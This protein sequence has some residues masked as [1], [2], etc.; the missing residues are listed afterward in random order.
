MCFGRA[1]V[2]QIISGLSAEV[3]NNMVVLDIFAPPSWDIFGLIGIREILPHGI[4]LDLGLLE[5]FELY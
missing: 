4:F 2:I 3:V 1:F 5:H